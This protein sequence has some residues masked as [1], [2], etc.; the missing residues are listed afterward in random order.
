MCGELKCIFP[1]G[2]S[3]G[4]ALTRDR[5]LEAIT[6]DGKSGEVGINAPAPNSWSSDGYD[7][8]MWRLSVEFN[9]F[10]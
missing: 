2:K 3:V 6:V 8:T 9:K 7:G 1:L 10:I 4:S 5:L